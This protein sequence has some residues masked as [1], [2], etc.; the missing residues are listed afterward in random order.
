[1]TGPG[2][3]LVR[4]ADD[5]LLLCRSE[6]AAERALETAT[7][8]LAEAGLEIHPEGTRIVDF[9]RGFRFLGHLFVRSMALREVGDPEEDAVE[10][11]RDV[12]RED[13][14][15]AEAASARRAREAEELARGYDRRQRVLHLDGKGRRLVLRNL[16]FSVLGEDDR[17]IIA[18]SP[19]RVD[20]IE[21]GPEAEAGIEAVRHALGTGT[22]LALL[23]GQGETLG[24]LT[25]AAMTDRAV[26]HLAQA[27]V[28]LDAGL[29][30]DLARRLVDGRL[31]NQRAQLQRLNRGPKDAEVL[32]AVRTLG[33][34][35]R[36]LPGA[37][38]V[39]ALR[40]HE[41]AAGAVYWPALGRLAAGV[42]GPLRRSRPAA[43][44]L[45]AA[46]NYLSA[47]LARDVRTGLMRRGLHAG[48]GVLHAAQDGGEACLWDLIEAFRAPLAEG[49]AVA[50]FNQGRLR[51][52]MFAQE[53]GAVRIGPEARAA[54]VRGYETAAAR[55]IASP[56][57]GRRQT[58]R[59]LMEE[60]A[61]A[62]A[63]HCRDP[64]AAPFA[65]NIIHA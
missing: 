41:G 65:P 26:L 16:S 38:G 34:I 47:L 49:L 24:W 31:R 46:L 54:I 43:D 35:I 9:D 60:E 44:P 18:V 55:V 52:E 62:Y 7:A 21:I 33:R 56:R 22:G 14:A 59:G 17:E 8:A 39:A 20:R 25:P 12:A 57:T 53:A 15:E 5:F 11:L 6:R 51:A 30:G 45:N 50:L 2:V 23:T 4:Y 10:L 36:K 37:E 27:R 61:G 28:A 64:E 1:M 19:G 32:A 29:A 63:A 48:I 42:D 40:G 3:R 13:D 58:W